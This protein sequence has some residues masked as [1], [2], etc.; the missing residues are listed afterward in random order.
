MPTGGDIRLFYKQAQG[1]EGLTTAN[2][3]DGITDAVADRYK[4]EYTYDAN[5]NIEIMAR[6]DGDGHLY[7]A[8]NYGYHTDAYGRKLRNRPYTIAK[9]QARWANKVA[10]TLDSLA[11]YSEPRFVVE[12]N[13]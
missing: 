13:P 10:H 3:W 6:H 8:M 5:G 2:T 11:A 4:S 7:D 1:V 12:L 9:E